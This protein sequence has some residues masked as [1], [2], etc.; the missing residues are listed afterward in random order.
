MFELDDLDDD[1]DDDPDAHFHAQMLEY[2]TVTRNEA[3]EWNWFDATLVVDTEAQGDPLRRGRELARETLRLASQ[4]REMDD[5][6][7][8]DNFIVSRVVG[9]ACAVVRGQERRRDTPPLYWI[10]TSFVGEV[11]RSAISTYR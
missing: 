6:R 8:S 4:H 10:A 7:L 1:L 2:P 3:G 11:V 5:F 9:G